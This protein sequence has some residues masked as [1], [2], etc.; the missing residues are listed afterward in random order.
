MTE[1]FKR[2]ISL[3]EDQDIKKVKKFLM[4]IK[5]DTLEFWLLSHKFRIILSLYLM[6]LC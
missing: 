6:R 3:A 1:C 4:N 5:D 2:I